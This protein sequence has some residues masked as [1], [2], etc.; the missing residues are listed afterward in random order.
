[1]LLMMLLSTDF[2]SAHDEFEAAFVDDVLA[3]L[4]ATVSTNSVDTSQLSVQAETTVNP[5]EIDV[6]AVVCVAGGI[7]AG[8][9]VVEAIK[10]AGYTWA[11]GGSS[12]HCWDAE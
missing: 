9:A 6:T 3:V 12:R 8:N 2:Q 11:L 5:S 4:V 1:M 7:E 10:G